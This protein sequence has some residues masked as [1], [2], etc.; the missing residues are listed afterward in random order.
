[1]TNPGQIVFGLIG[2]GDAGADAC[3]AKQHLAALK[4]GGQS[5]QKIAMRLRYGGDGVAVDRGNRT[6]RGVLYPI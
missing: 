3:V 6:V 4:A 1:M 5:V 2:K